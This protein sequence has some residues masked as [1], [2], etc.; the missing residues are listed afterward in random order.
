MRLICTP[1]ETFEQYATFVA[2]MV[3]FQVFAPKVH[4]MSH[5]LARQKQM[6]NPL[7]YANFW[8]EELNRTLKASCK[9]CA[10]VVFETSV[11]LRLRDLMASPARKRP[12]R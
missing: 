1:K 5:L 9:N 10:Q 11:L 8:D 4:I 6:G 2:L 3:P 12:L 7:A